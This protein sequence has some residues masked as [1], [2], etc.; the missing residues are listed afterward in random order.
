MLE[1]KYISDVDGLRAL[2]ILSVIFYHVGYNWIPGGFVGVDVFFVI[3]GYLITKNILFD[4]E[5]QNFSFFDFYVRRAR[6]LFPALFVTLII[7][8]IFAYQLFSP[9][10]LE[11]FGQSLLYANMSI[12][13][14]FFMSEAGYFDAES[15]LK[16][17]LHTWS[18]SVEEQFY[19]VWPFLLVVLLKLKN[20]TFI[21]AFLLF[22][23]IISLYAS[24]IYTESH[25]AMSFFMLPFRV[26][27]FSIGALV[28][29]I[30]NFKF[31]RKYIYD[32]LTIIGIGLILY[33][34]LFFTHSMSFPG[35]IALVPSIGAGLVIYASRFSMLGILFRN[36][37]MVG[38]GLISYSLYLVHWPLIV[39]YRYWKFE[40][41]TSIDKILFIFASFILGYLLWKF[42]E[43]PWRLS[44]ADDSKTHFT[45]IVPSLMLLISFIA[46]ITWGYK[47]FPT[48][49]SQEF[50]FTKEEIAQERARYW[51]KGKTD[52]SYLKGE[53]GENT[54][55][56]MGN[57]HG[58]DL[59]YALREN[60]SKL[61]FKFL[62][63]KH[64]C[65]NFGTLAN[66]DEYIELCENIKKKNFVRE[67]FEQIDKI[68]LHDDWKKVD[69]D[70]LKITLEELRTLSQAPI[71][72]FGPKM[73]YKR[74]IPS[75]INH[76]MH[77]NTINRYSKK[78]QEKKKI[79]LNKKLKK[80]FK[81]TYFSK[82]NIFYIDLLSTQCGNKMNECKIVSNENGKS[83][84][85]Y[86]DSNHFTE[87]GAY[88][89]GSKLK[90]NY[91]E[92]F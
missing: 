91:P 48:R 56:F 19:L 88:L 16:P 52:L 42:I 6:R 55:L 37:V 50:Q 83:F 8:F 38:I 82:S 7:S 87:K 89:F 92:I 51:K 20:K 77:L 68:Y 65:S 17:L 21:L 39:F 63:T 32:L 13:N 73:T 81:N 35:Y 9:V 58:T 86:F 25:P 78:F 67:N 64:R 31:S 3:S 11:R 41:I 26:F 30:E 28:I 22:S 60:D 71:Y 18:L 49:F 74:N 24:Y 80:M 72:V 33:S 79:S 57:S 69:L 27:E 14:F 46:A 10:D 5:Y 12:S 75:I 85:L 53:E 34:V 1:K 43:T 45:F 44:K 90:V 84:Y 4:V 59:I 15:N 40:E 47:G 76:H 61:N 2:A 23:A 70:Q 66:K 36:K 29:W 54:I 62:T